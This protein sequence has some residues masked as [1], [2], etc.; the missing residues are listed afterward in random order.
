MCL[1]FFETKGC[2]MERPQRKEKNT[3]R[4]SP[5][6]GTVARSMNLLV[7]QFSGAKDEQGAWR[8]PQDG[9]TM[10]FSAFV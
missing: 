9:D 4:I 1:R 2:C 8:T 10:F 3:A 7:M 5:P 6:G